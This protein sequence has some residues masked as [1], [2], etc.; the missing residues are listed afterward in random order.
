MKKLNT[1]TMVKVALLGALATVLMTLEIPL[2]FAPPFYQIDFSEVPV[3]LGAFSLG[4]VAA[5]AIELLKNILYMLFKG[6]IT[7]GVGELAN[8]VIGLSLV[9]PA[10]Y[11]YRRRKNRKNAFWGLL[12]GT[13]C[14]TLVG[15]LMNY[16][17]LLPAY[18]YFMG[19]PIEGLVAAGTQVN[20]SIQSLFT[21]VCFAT[22]PFN[23]LKGLVTSAAVLLVYKKLSP[24]LHR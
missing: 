11:I 18:S 17:V 7:A 15:A 1:H 22:V 23:L 9:L 16:F 6:T 12:V 21:L 3:L 10:A 5:I 2:P 13:G 14:I 20:A 4:P 19:L 8:L 24:L